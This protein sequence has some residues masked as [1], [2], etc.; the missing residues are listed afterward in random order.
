LVSRYNTEGPVVRIENIDKNTR[1]HDQS[2]TDYQ[3]V[4]I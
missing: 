1:W 2:V 3:N 4:G